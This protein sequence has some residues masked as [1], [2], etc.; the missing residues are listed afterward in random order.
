MRIVY[1]FTGTLLN[2]SSFIYLACRKRAP[3]SVV[4]LT[5]F[6]SMV[7]YNTYQWFFTMPTE[8]LRKNRFYDFLKNS[9]LE[10]LGKKAV[11]KKFAIFIGKYLKC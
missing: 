4:T 3:S 10:V 2:C 7:S 8:I 5:Q 6:L 9:R 11:L 1:R